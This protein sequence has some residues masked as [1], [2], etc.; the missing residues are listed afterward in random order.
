MEITIDDSTARKRADVVL[1][2]AF[3]SYSRAALSKL[4]DMQLVWIDGK[5]AKGGDKLKVGQVFKADLSP[6]EQ[7]PEVIEL[8]VL[9]ENEDV[10]VV[11]KPAGIISHARGRYWQEASVASFIRDKTKGMTGERAGIV[12]RLDRA[13]SGVMIAAKNQKA[14]SYLQ[15][16]FA[17]KKVSKKY[18]AL[19]VGTPEPPEAH[20]V[21][22]LLR[23][24]KIPQQFK[25]DQ[26]GKHAETM[27]KVEHTNGAV[28][29]VLLTPLT[30]RTHQLRIHM[31]YIGHSIVG[32]HLYGSEEGEDRLYLHAHTLQ[33][34][35][36][37][38]ELHTFEAPLPDEFEVRLKGG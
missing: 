5:P 34:R 19:V 18:V 7:E 2:D 29:K 9:F 32:D 21:A 36:P 3:T 20:I 1:A 33:I 37:S 26:A 15:K 28:S 11:N 16:Q 4:F 10:I 30:G 22:S 6:L 25:V 14:Q 17:D 13:T 31:Q 38:G 27:Y 23:N 8:P 35:V 12:H 24:P